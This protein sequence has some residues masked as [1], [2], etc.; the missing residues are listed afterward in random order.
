MP[1][2]IK[3]IV[4]RMIDAGESEDNIAAVIKEHT[5]PKPGSGLNK[6]VNSPS[7]WGEGVLDSINPFG[8]NSSFGVSESGMAGLKGLAGFAKG[9]ILDIP[10]NLWDASQTFQE[11]PNP[12]T[13]GLLNMGYR[14]TNPEKVSEI[15]E[16]LAA[17][18]GQMWETTKKA[19]TKPFEFGEMTGQ[20][21]GQPLVTEGLSRFAPSVAS[22]AKGVR[23][24]GKGAKAV[25]DIVKTNTPI[26]KVVPRAV[27]IPAMESVERAAGS[28]I[29]KL[30]DKLQQTGLPKVMRNSD[31][32]PTPFTPSSTTISPTADMKGSMSFPELTETPELVPNSKFEPIDFTPSQSLKSPTGP[33]KGS[34]S[35]PEMNPRDPSITL[36]SEYGPQP[37]TGNAITHLADELQNVN[38]PL[39]FSD[40]GTS[41]SI[42]NDIP[43]LWN[44]PEGP[45]TIPMS[46][47]A[48]RMPPNGPGLSQVASGLSDPAGPTSMAGTSL[49]EAPRPLPGASEMAPIS[50]NGSIFGDYQPNFDKPIITGNEL[51]PATEWKPPSP[52]LELVDE[53]NIQNN[54]SGDSSASVEA[55]NRQKSMK[56]KGKQFVVYDKTGKYRPL[57]GTDAV[58]YVPKKGETYGIQGPDGFH[59][60]HDNGGKIPKTK[61]VS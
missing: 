13:G 27:S 43:N 16:G 18:P 40:W 46:N 33:Q 44:T 17:T 60:L 28:G 54:A 20:I 22:M 5:K 58:D 24:V 48:T 29:S 12:M 50:T 32:G 51:P 30:A 21:T 49:L 56:V 9:A 4:Q 15:R 1:D 37:F 19:G 34:V 41:G 53:G 8:S 10:S 55:M 38:Q 25:G 7:S 35:Y 45:P 14:P 26:S 57:I 2:D 23:T 61:K 6:P 11:L 3:V 31:Y 36:N 47:P 52:E 39:Q 42:P 59:V